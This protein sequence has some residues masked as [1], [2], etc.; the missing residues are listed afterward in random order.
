MRDCV[1]EPMAVNEKCIFGCDDPIGEFFLAEGCFC[2]PDDQLQYLCA[3]H[4]H[5]SAAINGLE[6]FVYWGP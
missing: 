2:F 6:E 3:Q 1:A 5:K 4:L